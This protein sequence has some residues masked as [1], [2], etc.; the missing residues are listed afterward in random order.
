LEPSAKYE[1]M[2]RNAVNA[3]C[4]DFILSPKNIARELAA[5][6]QHPYVA[7]LLPVEEVGS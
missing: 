4:I 7:Q 3:G 1:G 6:S 2:P 5:F